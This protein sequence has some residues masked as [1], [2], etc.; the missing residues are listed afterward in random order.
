MKRSAIISVILMILLSMMPLEVFGAANLPKAFTDVNV[1]VGAAMPFKPPHKYICHQNPPDF[2]WPQISGAVSYEL[3]ICSDEALTNMVYHKLSIPN[4]YYSFTFPFE[5]GIYYWSVRYKN[6]SG[7]MSLWSAPRRFTM[8]SNYHEFKVK[9]GEEILAQIP[10]SHPRIWFTQDTLEDFRKK[11]YSVEGRLTYNMMYNKYRAVVGKAMPENPDSPSVSSGVV[12]DWGTRLQMAALCY[13]LTDN[14]EEKPQMLSLAVNIMK[15]FVS[16]KYNEVTD[17]TNFTANDIAYFELMFRVAMGYDWLYNEMSDSDREI[18]RRG[19]VGR[20][21]YVKDLS[22]NTLRSQPYNSHIWS[23]F[24]AY[25]ITAM[26]LAHDVEWVNDYLVQ[27]IDFQNPNFPP[28]SVED[29]GWSKGTR[30]WGHGAFSRDKWFIDC[31]LYGDYMNYYDKMWAQNETLW[32]LYMYP[33]NSYGSFGDGSNLQ[34]PNYNHIIGLSK[35]GKNTDNQVAYWLRNRIGQLQ[36]IETQ[37]FDALMY[38]DSNFEKGKSPVE[39]PKSHVF[40]D[41]GIAGMHSTLLNSKRISL[42]FRS[43]KY[44][45]YNHMHADQNSFII[46]AFGE[47]LAIKSGFYDSYHSVHDKNFTRQTFAH[48][49]VT[50]N[51][52]IGQK[53]DSMDAGGNIDFFLTHFDFDL[54]V[55][56]AS[57]AYAGGI[58]KF[59]R[60]IIYLRP[61]SYIIVDNLKAN[62]GDKLTFE[63]W[64][65]SPTGTMTVDE[66]YVKISN[67]N[68]CLGA[69]IMYPEGLRGKYEYN[70]KNPTN[71]IEYPPQYSYENTPPQD[72][73]YFQTAESE[74][75]TF[76]AGLNVN[77]GTERQ[78]AYEDFGTYLKIVPKDDTSTSVYVRK[79]HTGEVATKDGVVF[80]ATA[81]IL[82]N[83]TAMMAEGTKL[84]INGVSVFESPVAISAVMGK[85]QLSISGADDF[86]VK[87]N[88]NSKYCP[89]FVSDSSIREKDGRLLS[90]L[91]TVNGTVKSNQI[92]LNAQKGHYMFKL[93]DL[94]P[95]NSDELIPENFRGTFSGNNFANVSWEEVKGYKYDISVNNTVYENVT[96]PFEF[97]I[98][99][100]EVSAIRIKGKYKN[101]VSEWSETFYMDPFAIPEISY[102]DFRVNGKKHSDESLKKGDAVN[103][104]FNVN[105]AAYNSISLILAQYNSNG[106]LSGISVDEKGYVKGNQYRSSGGEII[107]EDGN[108]IKAFVWENSRAKPM[109]SSAFLQVEPVLKNISIDGK[110]IEGFAPDKYEY[111]LTLDSS[112]QVPVVK[113]ITGNSAVYTTTAYS[114]TATTAKAE[115][116]AEST[117]GSKAVY[118]VNFV[119]AE[120]TENVVPLVSDFQNLVVGMQ[121]EDYCKYVEDLTGHNP[122]NGFRTTK[123]I[124]RYSIYHIPDMVKPE[125]FT[126][127]GKLCY[128]NTQRIV[129]SI[130]K[131]SGLEN[132]FYIGP[133]PA[134]LQ[135]TNMANWIS[136]A[137]CGCVLGD[138]INE[139]QYS[140]DFMNIS[141]PWYS[142]KV[143]RD[144]KVTILSGDKPNFCE[145]DNK[146]IYTQL[147]E[148]IYTATRVTT[149]SILTPFINMYVRDYKAGDIVE[150]YNPC[151]GEKPYLG[152][153]TLIDFD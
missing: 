24:N 120:G 50:Y 91:I 32:A 26:A 97:K 129:E 117:D 85:G 54:V 25:G 72:R 61:D 17:S 134:L 38:A 11:L 139:T 58:D 64:L 4:S 135:S 67:G 28:M 95:I 138:K 46:E 27:M 122:D 130:E 74:E 48:N 88:F 124:P 146:W 108:T 9:T 16:W 126:V 87:V 2:T 141:V 69:N 18:I 99:E 98:P 86:S 33:D 60:S 41:Q 13:H 57:D 68:A 148:N 100:D 73:V 109:A 15:T 119:L 65:N 140:F 37:S 147:S 81:V 136:A 5:P 82:N 75:A 39:Y 111:T 70:Y 127:G 31:L 71:G 29:G 8:D 51:G 20:F 21:E 42:Y 62:P 77:Q 43:G 144:C 151:S 1:K 112:G 131:R 7:Q 47:R 114:N 115:I 78:F 89:Y 22:L 105:D 132:A 56:D 96:S 149:N 30:Y 123:D 92:N 80:N 10:K 34:L 104:E 103:V 45:S 44:G 63:W 35:L 52:G 101:I 107:S 55:G 19:L 142:F 113:G 143:N 133:D 94:V 128:R 83:N 40:I 118:V 90:E 150:L 152:Y 102:V 59:K 3:K 93:N 84:T 121:Y 49:S 6:A 23:Y 153:M 53:D 137:W 14:E 145:N 12:Q 36:N 125:T 116:T 66:N 110:F 106:T 76:V 79:A